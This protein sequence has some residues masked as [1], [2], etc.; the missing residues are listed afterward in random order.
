VARAQKCRGRQ[1]HARHGSRSRVAGVTRS[2]RTL[3]KCGS[4]RCHQTG[5]DHGAGR[6]RCGCATNSAS[7]YSASSSSATTTADTSAAAHTDNNDTDQGQHDLVSRLCK[8]TVIL[9]CKAL[10]KVWC[11]VRSSNVFPCSC[12]TIA[13]LR[14]SGVGPLPKCPV[15]RGGWRG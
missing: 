6:Y 15:C 11:W 5:F 2:H 10:T 7:R 14:K 3:F 9:A 8:R 4:N 13:R 12:R 1:C